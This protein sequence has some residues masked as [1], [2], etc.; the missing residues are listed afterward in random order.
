LVKV[1]TRHERLIGQHDQYRIR[2]FTAGTNAARDARTY[3]GR[4]GFIDNDPIG[5]SRRR[6]FDF[7][8]VG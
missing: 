2:M 5:K 1:G 6:I 7:F 3:S 4:I 8:G